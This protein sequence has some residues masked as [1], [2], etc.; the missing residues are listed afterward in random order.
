MKIITEWKNAGVMGFSKML[1]VI[2]IACIALACMP[3]VNADNTQDIQDS[4]LVTY[5]EVDVTNFDELVSAI[6]NY[7]NV[8]ITLTNNIE[9]KVQFNIESGKNVVINLNKKT[10][11][12]N[13]TSGGRVFGNYGTLTIN[14]VEGS[15]VAGNNNAYGTVNNFGTLIVNGGTYTNLKDSD[16][17][18]FYNRDGGLAIFNNVT[19]HGGGG[20]IASEINT[21]THING[22]YYENETYPSVENRGDMYITAG[23]FINT[24]CSSCDGKWGYTIRSG[25]NSESAYLQI[26]GESDDSVKVT[27]VQGGLA[28]IGGTSDIYNG[29]YS[30]E[31]CNVHTNG[32]SSFYAGYFTGESYT[33]ST[34]IYGGTFESFSKTA[35][36]VGNGNPPPDSGA[37]ES[38]TVMIYG[39][40]FIGGDAGKTSVSVNNQNYAIGGACITGG[41]FSSNVEAY[42]AGYAIQT[43]NE[44]IYTVS[45]RTYG[46]ASVGDRYYGSL[47][48]ALEY[49]QN[50]DT[51]KLQDNI[52]QEDGILFDKPDCSITLDLNGK[53]LSVEEGKNVNN[54]AFKIESGILNV[55]DSSAEKTGKIIA[56]GSGTTTSEGEGAFG[57][58]R[59]ESNGIIKLTGIALQNSRPWG[60]NVKVCGG[61]AYLTDVIIISSY[62]GGIEVTEA[63][64][65]EQSKKGKAEL[66]NCTIIQTGYNDWCSSAISVSGGS[67]LTVYGGSYESAGHA[68]YV[69]S[70]GGYI[71]VEDGYYY[72][73]I[74]S[75][76]AEIDTG[77]YPEYEGGVVINGGMFYGAFQITSPATLEIRGGAFDANPSD[78]VSGNVEVESVSDYYVV[79]EPL[80][81]VG[82]DKYVILDNALQ[83][84]PTGSTI[85]LLNDITD[86]TGLRIQGEKDLTLDMMGHTVTFGYGIENAVIDF[87]GT[88][89]LTI[90]GDG[91]FTIDDGYMITN[92][93]GYTFRLYDQ[94]KI[95][96]ENGTFNCGLTCIQLADE[97]S[98][99][100][101]G[102]HFSAYADW[103][104]KYWILNKIDNSDT[105]F[106]VSGGTFVNF[107]PGHSETEN[108]ADSFLSDGYYSS[109]TMD[110]DDTVW[111]VNRLVATVGDTN[112]SSIQEAMEAADGSAVVIETDLSDPVNVIS[113]TVE[114]DLNSHSITGIVTVGG[115]LTLTGTGTVSSVVLSSTSAKLVVGGPTVTSVTDSVSYYH[116]VSSTVDGVTTYSLART[117]SGGG[118]TVTPPVTPDEPGTDV[119]EHP[120]G[121]TTETT[122]ETTTNPDGSKTETTTVTEK[123]PE[124]NVTGSTVTETTTSEK[125]EDGVRETVTSTTVTTSDADG[126]KTG[127]TSASTT[128]TVTDSTTT[129][130]E[131]EEVMDA[132]D[133]VTSSTEKVTETTRIDGGTVTSETTEVK[134]ADGN[135]TSST[136]SVRAESDDGDVRTEATTE[137]GSTTVSTTVSVSSSGRIDDAL[138]QQ[139]VAQ[140]DAVSEKVSAESPD[141]VIQIGTGSGTDVTLSPESMSAIAGTGAEFR[142]ISETGSMQ[143]D[144][145]VVGTLTEP[146]EDVTVRMAES[147]DSELTEAQLSAKG[148]RF[149]VTLTATVGTDIVH[150]LGGTV[151]VTIPY[152]DIMGSD[153]SSLG[154]FYIDGDGV[155]TFM[156]SVYD[157]ALRSFVFQTDHFSLFVVDDLP[158]SESGDD[159]LLYAGIAAVMAVAIVAVAVVVLH[160]KH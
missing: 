29:Q 16:A 46:V 118:G 76:C 90:V 146:G 97:S 13:P 12:F 15:V 17:F 31:A 145:D 158:A 59:V 63:D 67:Y 134:D 87:A 142:V 44:G 82:E 80:F 50:G 88:T 65:G 156:D 28:V 14:G 108:P 138:I 113:E 74:G 95:L 114:M 126:N 96:I 136:E 155:R 153:P 84:A 98:A 157:R 23:E 41:T 101:H 89:S 121:S 112:Y 57:T 43:E 3:A 106:A 73:N 79:G 111:T 26:K 52:D 141:R 4:V 140:S 75:I 55:I 30:T 159:T 42:V 139:A 150:L 147:D 103:N 34:S 58:F 22:G 56:T 119:E 66:I 160:R 85:I 6:E 1:V 5:T 144:R 124:G 117:S 125:E 70:S 47:N 33:T 151:T 8:E 148:D 10:I 109:P 104:G 48:D 120:D 116:V 133:N 62:G 131:K 127:S 32:T 93:L 25:E 39:G 37:G 152:A 107:D 128:T 122:T 7:T 40:T 35:I 49:A 69:F 92:S 68:I 9:S 102:G 115:S 123:D 137:S 18:N 94:A 38:S 51:I 99:E 2:A 21:T 83:N 53:T 110:G 60:M 36:L 129:V 72:G 24:S 154:V 143:L 81:Q 86:R 11:T 149:G 71:T 45:L 130:V 27:G 19:I 105:T 54:R 135:V 78:Y 64:L 20:C 61:E 100:I 91:T 77:T 132:D